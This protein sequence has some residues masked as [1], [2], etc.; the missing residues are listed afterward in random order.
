MRLDVVASQ[1]QYADHLAP[2]WHALDPAERGRWSVARSIAGHVVDRLHVPHG[3]VDLAARSAR[4]GGPVM[5]ASYADLRNVRP[6]PTVMVNH[7]AGQTYDGDPTA[8]GHPSYSGGRERGDVA[9]YLCPG[10]RDVDMCRAAQPDVPAVAVGVPKLDRWH[11]RPAVP[12]GTRPTVAVSWHA[13][14]GLCPETRSAWP[15]YGPSALQVLAADPRW[16]LL[17]HAHPRAWPKLRRVY[18]DLGIP[19]TPHF[20]DVLDHADAYVVDN[21]S[22]LYE[23]ASTG[24]PVVAL[25]APWYRRHIEHGLRFWTLIPGPQVDQPGVLAETIGLALTDPPE[26]QALRRD[27]IARV[28]APC[29]GR[30]AIRAAAAIRETIG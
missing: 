21:S 6:R 25:N 26:L 20:D 19:A 5:V 15:H 24:R 4:R 29:D 8:A 9:L 13:E 11:A 30:A 10:Q 7:G 28:Y 23:F 17:G 27:V 14:I 22:T 3:A 16:N 1:R 12:R 2:I 18:A